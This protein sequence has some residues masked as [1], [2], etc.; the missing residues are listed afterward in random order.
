[1]PRP[2]IVQW[3]KTIGPKA[4]DD[5]PK[6]PKESQPSTCYLRHIEALRFIGDE[7]VLPALK[8]FQAKIPQGG[9]VWRVHLEP[10]GRGSE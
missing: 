7:S 6:Q 9:R 3:L 1:M 4:L 10:A 8:E 5:I 2:V